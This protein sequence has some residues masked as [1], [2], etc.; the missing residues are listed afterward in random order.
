MTYPDVLF[1][2]IYH[3]IAMIVYSHQTMVNR[4]F[5]QGTMLNCTLPV[6]AHTQNQL[7]IQLKY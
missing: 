7:Y 4:K 2:L 6:R 5:A 3:F 1:A